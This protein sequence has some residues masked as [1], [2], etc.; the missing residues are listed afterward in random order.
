MHMALWYQLRVDIDHESVLGGDT[1][2]EFYVF[3]QF[4][5]FCSI[6]P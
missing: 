2:V 1:S 6:K 3:A 4:G 5:T